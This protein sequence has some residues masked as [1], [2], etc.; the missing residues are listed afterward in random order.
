[1]DWRDIPSLSALR[2]FEATA[3]LGSFSAAA[4][5]LNVTH[6]AIGQHVRGL[7]SHF[8]ATLMVREGRGMELTD[9]GAR[10]AAAVGEGFATIAAG[11]A[12]I[13]KRGEDEP[14]KIALTPAFAE[15]WL[16]PRIGAFW[17]DHPEVAVVLAP[18]TDLVDLR[19]DGFD[20]AIRYGAGVWNGEAAELLVQAK[21][22]V[23]GTPEVA[24][25]AT[26]EGLLSMHWILETDR[27]EQQLWAQSQGLDYD[28]LK[29]T[30]M[31]TNG[32]VLSAV[33]A[34]M[35]LSMQARALVENDL[36]AGRL[37]CLFEEV[38]SELGYYIIP[39]PGVISPKLK[40]FLRWLR[41]S[42]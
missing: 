18:S 22:V 9:T 32:L 10:L 20:L 4:R 34:G 24:A 27:I 3:R 13:R 7:E 41:N 25:R 2:A 29:M 42:R 37:V 14:L 6:A 26:Q 38:Q 19:R 16:M 35:G 21:T 33:R 36:K 17:A 5:E 30:S 12:D 8:A 28:K 31:P 39:R 15:N 1:M 23:I 40:V 11:V